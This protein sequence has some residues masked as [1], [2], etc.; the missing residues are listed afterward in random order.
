ML[1]Q[2]GTKIG[3]F[4][5]ILYHAAR[6]KFEIPNKIY[7]YMMWICSSPDVSRVCTFVAVTPNEERRCPH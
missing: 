2:S 5:K 7:M 1:E 6:F 3:S 4:L